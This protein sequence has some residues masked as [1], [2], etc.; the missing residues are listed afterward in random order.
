MGFTEEAARAAL[1]QANGLVEPAIELLL[2]GGGAPAGENP[3]PRERAAADTAG[4]L[5][6]LGLNPALADVP[7]IRR[8]LGGAAG[9]RFHGIPVEP[10]APARRAEIEA[11]PELIAQFMAGVAASQSPRVA[12]EIADDVPGFLRT[13]GLDPARFDVAA[14]RAA[15]EQWIAAPQRGGAQPQRTAVAAL[16]QEFAALPP[17]VVADVVA[18]ANGDIDCA[19]NYLR[20]LLE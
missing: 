8:A 20:Q 13:I 16:Q 15:V 3:D 11:N 2:R 19:R 9:T 5:R 7:S 4:F 1:A 17:Q 14:A 6:E 12:R 18:N 10:L